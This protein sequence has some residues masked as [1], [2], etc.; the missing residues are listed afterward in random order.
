V[1]RTNKHQVKGGRGE[2]R[3]RRRRRGEGE[4]GG[5]GR[6]SSPTWKVGVDRIARSPI[7]VVFVVFASRAF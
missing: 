7:S 2:R 3:R 1:D 4:T 5:K 6:E